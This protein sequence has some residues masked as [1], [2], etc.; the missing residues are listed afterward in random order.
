VPAAALRP[1][2]QVGPVANRGLHSLTASAAQR[3]DLRQVNVPEHA[4]VSG[5]MTEFVSRRLL[6]PHLGRQH[7]PLGMP[8]TSS[9]RATERSAPGNRRLYDIKPAVICKQAEGMIN[10]GK[11]RAA[12]QCDDLFA[13]AREIAARQDDDADIRSPAIAAIA[14]SDVTDHRGRRLAQHLPIVGAI[15]SIGSTDSVIHR[16]IDAMED[17]DRRSDGRDCTRDS[18]SFVPTR[19][20]KKLKS[21]GCRPDA[22][23][24]HQSEGNGIGDGEKTAG[25]SWS[26]ARHATN[27]GADAKR[28]FR[29]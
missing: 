7:R 28:D 14:D 23:G 9:P 21:V 10:G 29:T 2:F 17:G 26:R 18:S 27:P 1:P 11:D 3:A 20:S 5:W 16:R 4:R 15:A 22:Q 25:P 12:R 13:V 24:F 19:N 8:S 6:Q